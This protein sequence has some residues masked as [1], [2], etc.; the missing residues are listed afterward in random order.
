MPLNRTPLNS[1]PL[2]STP[3]SEIIEGDAPKEPESKV[4]K[5]EVGAAIDKVAETKPWISSGPG[6]VVSPADY[7]FRD[8]VVRLPEN[9]QFTIERAYFQGELTDKAQREIEN[10]QKETGKKLRYF[11]TRYSNVTEEEALFNGR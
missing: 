5:F 9:E 4:L 10:L 2:N 6:P 8:A 3:L 11:A 1:T 7:A